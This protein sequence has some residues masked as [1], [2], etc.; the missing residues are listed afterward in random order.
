MEDTESTR[1]LEIPIAPLNGRGLISKSPSPH[2]PSPLLRSN[3]S[4]SS[5]GSL[6]KP[7]KQDSS[8]GSSSDEDMFDRSIGSKKQ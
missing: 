2:H 4:S 7:I 6:K 8:S 5:Q 3:N 1:H